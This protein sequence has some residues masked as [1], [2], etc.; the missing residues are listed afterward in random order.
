VRGL[1]GSCHKI[2]DANQYTSSQAKGARLLL[3]VL[4][5]ILFRFSHQNIQKRKNYRG[6]Q[7]ES[8]AL[9]IALV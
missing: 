9:F 6:R 3:R 2:I 1:Q 7:R 4:Q 8:S 5:R